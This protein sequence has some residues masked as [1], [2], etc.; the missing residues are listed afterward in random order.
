MSLTL[1]HT[2]AAHLV[3]GRWLTSGVTATSHS[4][5]DGSALGEYDDAQLPLGEQAVA[6]ARRAFATT[7][8]A[9]DRQLRAKVLNEMADAIEAATDELALMLARE[10]G[11][12][13]PEAH[14]ELSLTPSKLR[15]YAAMA[16][17]GTGRGDQAK[18]GV[19]S[20][21]VPVP[22]GV[23]GVIVPWNSP[24]VLAVRSFAP[25]LAAGCTVVVKMA[26]Q[27]ALVNARLAEI[28]A[29]CPSLPPGVLNVLTESGSD[30]AKHLVDSP[31]VDA[32][33]Y[34]GSTA[35]GRQ[36]MAAAAPRLK[37]VSLEL[38]G[39]TPMIVFD[40]ADLDRAVGTIV[41]GITTFSGQF[42]MTGSRVLVQRGVADEV[43][44]RLVAALSAVRVGPGDA[45][46]SQMGPMIDRAGR[47]RLVAL[48][49]G[50]LGD[51]TVLV[52]GGVP[53]EP[54]LADGAYYR[55]ALLEVADLCSPLIQR[56]LF[57]PIATFEVFADE[58]DAVARANATE[59]GLAASVWTAD[60][61]R[62][63]RM[64]D[65]L[66]AGTVWLNAWALVLDQFEEGGVK[67]SGLGRLNGH[68]AVEEFQEVKHLVQVL[69]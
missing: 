62:G 59:Y 20:T 21:L 48:V 53:D 27:T 61:Q 69:G 15:Y 29:A 65:A 16:L 52:P 41:A 28:L 37:R 51:A 22:V 18:P 38:G 30:I 57:G 17:T 36:I 13:L 46:E 67:Q 68:R 56:E 64:A 58:A 2:P 19:L 43:R 35:V 63:L 4:P 34:T 7:D 50:H 32:I 31:E 25:A 33:S 6:A 45:P 8:W 14:F 10:N 66:E 1:E 49:D 55:P 60:G 5:A 9:R 12:I 24:V 26:A 42:C 54:A 40:D 11:K 3:D 44:S 47:D 39:K 23:A